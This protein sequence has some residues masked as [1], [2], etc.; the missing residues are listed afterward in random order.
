MYMI[1]I[2]VTAG[3]LYLLVG[4]FYAA[5]LALLAVSQLDQFEWKNL[6]MQRALGVLLLCV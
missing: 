5:W 6:K 1:E 4:I 3:Y 2:L